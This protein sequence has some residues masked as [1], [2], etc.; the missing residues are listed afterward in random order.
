MEAVYFWRES[1]PELGWL[2]Q[3]Y[4]CPFRDDENPERIYQTAEHYM[5][6]Q[7]A[8]LFDD[9]EAGRKVKGFS[10][11]KWTANRE[12]IVRKGNLL[13]FTN[14]VTE[15][16]LC[17]GTTEDSAPIEGSLMD[18]LLATGTKELVEASPTDRIWGV[19]Y[20]ARNAPANRAKWGKNLLG[21][22]LME[23]REVLRQT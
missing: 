2:S 16:G 20:S 19:G 14:A 17:K 6:Y 12:V 13:K 23:V 18:M 1:D 21:K 9:N 10:D 22:V 7:K 4:D 11:K 8:I 3:W 5:M 15:K